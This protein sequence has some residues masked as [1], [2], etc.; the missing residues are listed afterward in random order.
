MKI[1][2]VTVGYHSSKTLAKLLESLAQQTD[3]DFDMFLINNSQDDSDIISTFCAQYPFVSFTTSPVNNGFAG[4][5]NIG[6]RKAIADGADW[7]I[8]LNPD[9]ETGPE[10]ISELR[11]GLKDL[12]GLVGFPIQE[13]T[14]KVWGGKIEW[15]KP[16]L[17]QNTSHPHSDFYTHGGAMA[18]HRETIEKIGYLPEEYFLY[19]EDVAYSIKAREAGIKLTYLDKPTISHLVS[20][21]TKALGSATVLRYHYRNSLYLNFEHAPLIYKISAIFWSVFVFVKQVFK[22]LTNNHPTESRAIMAG[23]ADFYTEKMGRISN[24][25]KVGIECEQIEEEIWGVGKIITKLL[26]DISKRP[27]LEK[28]FEFHLY[29]KSKIPKLSFLDNPIFYKKVIE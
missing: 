26:E 16:E 10:L 29:F 19:F 17:A 22:L 4:G 20:A 6:I 9:T 11:A 1:S 5:N 12:K 23:I 13:P 18:I 8:L 21:S 14:Q 15:L 28:D 27:E 24:K 2:I 3:K 25:I 7:V